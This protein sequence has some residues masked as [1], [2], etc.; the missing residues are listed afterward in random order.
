MKARDNPT[1]VP[2]PLDLDAAR[3]AWQRI[4]TGNSMLPGINFEQLWIERL[5]GFYSTTTSSAGVPR[6][7]ARTA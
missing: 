3:V 1:C 5:L 6:T 2:L 4:V 7:A